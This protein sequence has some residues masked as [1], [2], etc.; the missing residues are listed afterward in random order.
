MSEEQ[1]GE[2]LLWSSSIDN[3]TWKAEVVQ[4]SDTEATI[5][6]TKMPSEVVHMEN[7]DFTLDF[8]KGI[9]DETLEEWQDK[10]IMLVDKYAVQ[11]YEDTGISL[12]EDARIYGEGIV[13]I[14]A[15]IPEGLPRSLNFDKGWY[16]LVIDLDNELAKV[17]E[18]YLIRQIKEVKG[19]LVF[20][21]ELPTK[22]L[23]CCEEFHFAQTPPE[24]KEGDAY[25]QWWLDAIK[26]SQ[27]HL[28]TE[29]HKKCFAEYEEEQK[30]QLPDLE[31]MYQIVAEYQDKAINTCEACGAPGELE[32][33]FWHKTLCPK[34]L[35][36]LEKIT[37]EDV[38]NA[39]ELNESISKILYIENDPKPETLPD[40]KIIERF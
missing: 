9:S 15:R 39:K 33:L 6:I 10:A 7:F 11:E 25:S 38:E 23:S 31:A 2:M 16:G 3:G 40:G 30:S 37:P 14:F 13:R 36:E 4:A 28:E 1:K 8:A 24:D 19:K 22:S 18:D 26:L 12:P 17:R 27:E 32:T 20:K 29:E 35:S 21:I 5:Y 34:H